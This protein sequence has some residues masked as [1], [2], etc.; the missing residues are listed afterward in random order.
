MGLVDRSSGFQRVAPSL[1]VLPVCSARCIFH[2]PGVVSVGG[3][4]S[5][6]NAES[7]VASSGASG[8]RAILVSNSACFPGGPCSTP[9]T[10]PMI[11]PSSRSSTCATPVPST[12][13]RV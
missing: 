12:G 8:V 11:P 6:K 10:P 5:S 3:V 9:D 13:T 7:G 4:M 2:L 1:P